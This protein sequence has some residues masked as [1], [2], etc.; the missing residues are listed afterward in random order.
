MNKQFLNLFATPILDLPR[1]AKRGVALVVDFGLCVFTAW[2]A[3]FLR[4]GV[5]ISFLDQGRWEGGLISATIGSVLI[6]IPIFISTGFYRAIFRYSGWAALVTVA[7]SVTI[8]LILYSLVFTFIGVEAVPRTVG[9]IQPI[10]LLLFVGGSRLFVRLWLGDQY[11]GILKRMSRAKVLIY[12]AGQSGRQLALAMEHSP[13]MQIV[14]FLDDDKKLHGNIL[15][16][17][18]IYDP[19]GLVSQVSSLN[20]SQVL[21]AIPGVNR[22]RRNEILEK[23]QKAHV[24]VRTLPNVSDLVQGRVSF[25]DIHELDID[26]LLKR[27]PVLPDNALLGKNIT[28]KVVMVTGAGGSIGS[29]LCRQI[30]A[31]SPS[32]LLLVDQSEFALYAIHEELL[33]KAP[34]LSIIPLI[35]SV[36]DYQRIHQIISTWNPNTLYHAAAYK[37]V[38][39]VEQNMIEGIKNNIFGTMNTAKAAMELQVDHFVL[40]S[41]DKAV[42]PTNVMG[43]TKRFAE[44]ILQAKAKLSSKTIFSMVRFGNVLGSSG[45]VV[46]KFRQQIRAGGPITLTHAE[47]TRF[48]MTIPEAAQ[49]VIQAGAMAQGGDVFVLDMGQPVKIIE[50]AKRMIELSGLTLRDQTNPDGDIAIEITGLRPG[51]KLYEEILIGNNPEQTHHPRILKAHEEY[52]TWDDLMPQINYLESLINDQNLD[53]IRNL[54]EKLPLGY[55]P[56]ESI[57]DWVHLENSSFEPSIETIKN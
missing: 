12:G 37:H 9:I 35:A 28:E 18:P 41:T 13:E 3:F 51:E 55:S 36:Q 5:P 24:S 48:F 42:R 40:V 16:G 49:L 29:E 54:M 19:D 7:R 45:S 22:A 52:L 50:L 1:P 2:L 30:V 38:P 56:N 11:H 20:V 31:L 23:V 27:E 8:Y 46:P 17:L 6:A 39:L 32:K 43:A 21:L 53:E 14:G 44:L 33:E 15:N 26:D 47:V 25:S 57:T 10:L 34:E 4:L